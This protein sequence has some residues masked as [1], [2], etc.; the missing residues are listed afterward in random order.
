MEKV[1]IGGKRGL[2]LEFDRVSDDTVEIFFSSNIPAE[3][4]DKELK[5]K[6]KSPEGV[7]LSFN[8]PLSQVVEL[9]LKMKT[10][11]SSM[12]DK[13]D[14]VL[15]KSSDGTKAVAFFKHSVNEMNLVALG[16]DYSQKKA[17]IMYINTVNYPYVL[18]LA[19][20]QAVLQ[21]FPVLTYKV[22][23]VLFAYDRK[24]KL[25]TVLDPSVDKFHYIERDELNVMHQLLDLYYRENVIFT[26]SFTPDRNIFIDKDETFYV[27]DKKFDFTTFRQ[28]AYLTQI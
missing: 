17:G 20:I 14:G 15:F 5:Q 1:K 3:Y 18:L 12:N 26:H 9:Y 23:D 21:N 2:L 6:V 7:T 28:I 16:I 8:V 10:F 13:K 27:N 4:Y 19:Y 11:D 22:A 24:E 25:L